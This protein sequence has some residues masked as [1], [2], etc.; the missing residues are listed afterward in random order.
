[1]APPNATSNPQGNGRRDSMLDWWETSPDQ[2]VAGRMIRVAGVPDP[3]RSLLCVADSTAEP[4][5]S[6]ISSAGAVRTEHTHSNGSHP[7]R[8]PSMTIGNSV[9]DTSLRTSEFG[10]SILN[11]AEFGD[12]S[13]AEGTKR[14]QGKFRCC[15]SSLRCQESFDEEQEL[16]DHCNSH[17]RSKSPPTSTTCPFCVPGLQTIS[18]AWEAH[19]QHLSSEHP[20][21]RAEDAR[22]DQS[23]FKHLYNIRVVNNREFQELKTRGRLSAVPEPYVE[24]ARSQTRRRQ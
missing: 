12:R 18:R 11:Y 5:L 19:M 17:F 6:A 22:P 7:S 23:L 1:M 2:T 21:A 14:P 20:Y 8:A 10:V 16:T 13:L 15:F 24:T 3:S 4:P 9:D